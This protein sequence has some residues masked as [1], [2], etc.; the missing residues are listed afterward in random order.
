MPHYDIQICNTSGAKRGDFWTQGNEGDRRGSSS[1]DE[2]A[3]S[4]AGK[5][6]KET[7]ERKEDWMEGGEANCKGKVSA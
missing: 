3:D 7:E 1:E 6:E 4:R 5:E 2:V